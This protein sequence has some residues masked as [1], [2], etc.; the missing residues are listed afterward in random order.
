MHF[1]SFDHSRNAATPSRWG[2][3][4]RCV[5]VA[6]HGRSRLRPFRVVVVSQ[7]I[8]AS[9]RPVNHLRGLDKF[10]KKILNL[11]M[12]GLIKDEQ[13][14]FRPIHLRSQQ[15]LRLVDYITEGFK[16]NQKTVAVFLV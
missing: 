1:K 15:A 8:P 12:K 2:C 11:L 10:F 13:F 7:R 9:Y 5:R 14:G 16:Y 3:A 6:Y 4:E